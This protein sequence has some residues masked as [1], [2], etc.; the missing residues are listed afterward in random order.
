[1]LIKI[2]WTVIIEIK[3]LKYDIY[4]NIQL[5][6]IFKK[7]RTLINLRINNGCHLF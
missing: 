3:I 6:L 7:D 5:I 4:N 2:V 1:M